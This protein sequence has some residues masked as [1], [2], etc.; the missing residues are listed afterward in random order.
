[1]NA[2]PTD[3]DDRWLTGWIEFGL[4]EFETYLGKHS[5]FDDYCARSGDG[6]TPASLTPIRRST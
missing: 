2:P 5:M 6:C 1:M 3:V 4:R